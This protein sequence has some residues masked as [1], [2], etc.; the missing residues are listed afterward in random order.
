MM[1]PSFR[2]HALRVA[3]AATLV[4]LAIA[5]TARAQQ[6]NTSAA[7]A[8]VGGNFIA[9]ARG[10]EAVAWN[11]ANLGLPGNPGFSLTLL[12]VAASFTLDPIT[13]GDIKNAESYKV[14]NVVP[15]ATRQAWLDKVTAAGGEKGTPSGGA[16]VALSVGPFAAQF[17]MTAFGAVDLNP[18]AVEAILFGNVPATGSGT[19]GSSVRTFNFR[20]SKFNAGGVTTAAFSYGHAFGSQ[21]PGSGTLAFGATLKWVGGAFVGI[22][23]DAG[24]S[25]N[26]N[27]GT[28][29]FPTVAT[30]SFQDCRDDSGQLKTGCTQMSGAGGFSGSGIGADIGVSWL[31]DKLGLSATIQNVFNSFSWDESVLAYVPGL[32][33]FDVN[34]DTTNF[35]EQP[36]ANAPAALK[37]AIAN[38]KLKPTV[39]AGLAYEWRKD[40]T[41]SADARQQLG[42]DEAIVIGPKTSVG[43][44]VEYRGIPMLSLR[45]GADYITGGT[46]LSFGAGL[47]IRRYE[48]GAAI[49]LQQG[50]NKGTS[51]LVNLFSIR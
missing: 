32:G 17:G 41:L 19:D 30:R 23:Q 9:R 22:A 38:Y 47:R 31:R 7:A 26:A 34:G 4:P 20:N 40:V 48:L 45:G 6:L 13:L 16:N 43:G 51:L 15:R 1:R 35:D 27:G 24:S 12:P 10:Y 2:L 5:P 37:N 8:G 50:D 11:P 49:A 36:Y 46:A 28:I 18:D 29:S 25:I 39:S 42:G 44:G 3:G 21:K 33:Q 14:P